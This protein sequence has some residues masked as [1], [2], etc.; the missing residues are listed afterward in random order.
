MNARCAS[1]STAFLHVREESGDRY[2]Y[3]LVAPEV[4]AAVRKRH[5]QVDEQA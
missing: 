4:G 5:L 1:I 3:M 2:A